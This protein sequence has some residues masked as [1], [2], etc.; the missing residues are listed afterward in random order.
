[1]APLE[2]TLASWTK[3]SSD[4]EQEKQERTER[5][6]REAVKNHGAFRGCDLR[7]YTKGSY[8]NNTNVRTDSDVD[9][10]V[11]C[12]ECF[13]WD[14]ESPSAHTSPGP[15]K[16]TWTP[17][18][19][20]SELAAA[21]RKKFPGQVDT[22]GST[23]MR[24]HSGTARIDADVVPCFTCKYY[25]NSGTVRE[26]AKTFKT[27]GG[28]LVNYPDQHLA[29]GRRKNENTKRY[30]KQAVRIMKRV[31]NAMVEKGL[32]REVPSYFVE[33]LIYNCPDDIFMKSTW[34]ATVR[35]I[36]VHI[37]NELDGA[38]PTMP[39]GRWLEVNRCKWLF[40]DDQKWSRQDGREFAKAAWNYLGF[41]S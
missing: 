9:V 22:K 39:G 34:E 31:E 10:A 6:I 36:I 35:V 1:M 19:L 17:E 23:A 15:Y 21:M 30:F 24:I 38:E 4:T 20:R 25:F 14:A 11:Q 3:P 5:M 40:S 7:V 12:R 18:K 26:G 32:H 33:C 28:T 37:W 8:A 41:T 13:Y 29:E 2:E 27:S 16:G